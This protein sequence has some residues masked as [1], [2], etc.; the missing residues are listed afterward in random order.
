MVQNI[1][2]K[3]HG[4]FRTMSIQKRIQ[5][6]PKQKH[7]EESHHKFINIKSTETMQTWNQRKEIKERETR[8]A[9]LIYYC[10]TLQ[11]NLINNTYCTFLYMYVTALLHFC[12]C[13]KD[14]Y[15]FRELL[16]SALPLQAWRTS[17]VFAEFAVFFCWSCFWR[18]W[19]CN[20]VFLRKIVFFASFVKLHR[21]S[22]AGTVL[23]LCSIFAHVGH[24]GMFA[25]TN[26]HNLSL[27]IFLCIAPFI[28]IHFRHCLA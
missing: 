9:A 24:Q 22:P 18:F 15:T 26:N 25:W 2:R 5:G 14:N 19:L 28:S 4:S 21:V 10:K 7:A 1:S 20:F 13:V 11:L 27:C 16:Y 17:V 8:S 3:T 23:A 12:S 6:N